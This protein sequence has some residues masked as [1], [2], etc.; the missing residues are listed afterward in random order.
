VKLVGG[1]KLVEGKKSQLSSLY[2][3]NVIPIGPVSG[4]PAAS[5]STPENFTVDGTTPS[6]LPELFCA[7]SGEVQQINRQLSREGVA[8][9][10][11][12]RDMSV[13]FPLQERSE[14]GMEKRQ[15]DRFASKGVLLWS[16]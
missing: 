12:L 14:T 7:K 5:F 3:R 2:R 8:K 10:K 11:F 4:L 16:G 6:P 15:P 1:A 13:W 9:S